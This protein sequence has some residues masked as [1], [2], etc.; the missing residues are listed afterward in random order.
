MI[1]NFY[2]IFYFKYI[3]KKPKLK[4]ENKTE[5]CNGLKI[6]KNINF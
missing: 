6:N 5:I 4:K 2:Y 1:H 3:I